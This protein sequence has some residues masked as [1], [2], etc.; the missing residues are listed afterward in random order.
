MKVWCV[1][2]LCFFGGGVPV[3]LDATRYRL[4]IVGTY[5]DWTVQKMLS[6]GCMC[7]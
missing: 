5:V 1:V 4:C 3:R 7:D 2:F 6:L